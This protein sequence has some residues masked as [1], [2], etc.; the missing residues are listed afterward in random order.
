MLNS[1]YN[2]HRDDRPPLGSI[3]TEPTEPTKRTRGLGSLFE[4]DFTNF[5]TITELVASAIHDSWCRPP[6]LLDFFR[7]TISKSTTL[8]RWA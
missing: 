5:S 3:L 2:G 6:I 1:S 4:P 7:F 8:T